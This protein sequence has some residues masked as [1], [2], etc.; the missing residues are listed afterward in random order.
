VDEGEARHIETP[1]PYVFVPCCII[2]IA[3]DVTINLLLRK[4]QAARTGDTKPRCGNKKQG[5]LSKPIK[6]FGKTKSFVLFFLFM[7]NTNEK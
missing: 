6:H 1:S 2:K 5:V 3:V 7:F 4:P